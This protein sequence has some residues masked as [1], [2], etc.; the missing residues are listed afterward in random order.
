MSIGIETKEDSNFDRRILI[1]MS[2][3]TEGCHLSLS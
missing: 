2:M 1:C 3:R